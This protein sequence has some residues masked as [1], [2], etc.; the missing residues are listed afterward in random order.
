[1]KQFEDMT[2]AYQATMLQE[3]AGAAN[4]LAHPAAGAAAMGALGLGMLGHVFGTWMGVMA[5]ATEASQRLMD[6]GFEP[7]ASPVDPKPA[8]LKLV[9][10]LPEAKLV[11]AS[12]AR[13]VKARAAKAPRV[14]GP[15]VVKA[16]AVA[17]ISAMVKPRAA[18]APAKPDDLKRI[19][20]IGPKLETVLNGLG[21]WNFGQIA[22]LDA[23][24]VAWLDDHLGFAGRIGRDDWIGQAK[25]LGE[26]NGTGTSGI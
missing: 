14:A 15:K 8:K 9:S 17:A 10:S 20:G 5:G 16:E 3:F 18:V 11:R 2:K 4:L 12:A 23:P 22:A 6:G 1:M 7:A 26:T 19:A 21:L 25:T 24:E 13:A